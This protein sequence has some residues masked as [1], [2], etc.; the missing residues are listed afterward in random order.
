MSI[1]VL[2][3]LI[4]TGTTETVIN[5][6]NT[7]GL[8]ITGGN[9]TAP[10]F[11]GNLT[12]TSTS[13]LNSTCLNGVSSACYMRTDVAAT[14][15]AG[16]LRIND[17][18]RTEFGTDNDMNIWHDGT[19]NFIKG[20][21]GH[22]IMVNGSGGDVRIQAVDGENSIVAYPN[23]CTTL[24]YDNLERLKTTAT[25]VETYG[26][27][28]QGQY[29]IGNSDGA[30]P[31]WA[32]IFTITASQAYTTA[33]L[34]FNVITRYT[35]TAVRLV[36]DQGDRVNSWWG[37]YRLYSNTNYN[38]ISS[39]N[40]LV[41]RIDN[42][43]LEVWG[44]A[45]FYSNITI[46]DYTDASS[47]NFTVTTH[48]G[49]YGTP[50]TPG[51]FSLRYDF[52]NGVLLN[53][54]LGLKATTGTYGTVETVGTTTGWGGFLTNGI[55]F[56]GAGGSGGMYDDDNNRWMMCGAMGA[57]VEL[58]HNGNSKLCT[59]SAGVCVTGEIKAEGAPN[60][61]GQIE[62]V[63]ASGVRGYTYSDGGGVGITDGDP[64]ND[65]IYLYPQ[66]N[67]IV[68]YTSTV[69]RGYF[70]NNG[71]CVSN[72][73]QGSCLMVSSGLGLK[74]STETYGTVEAIGGNN[75][76]AGYVT[77]G[78]TLMSNGTY[79]GL[80]NDTNDAWMLVACKG[81]TTVLY[82]NGNERICTTG[83]GVCVPGRMCTPYIG[84]DVSG[85]GCIVGGNDTAGIGLANN[86]H[87]ATWYGFSVGPSITGQPIPEGCAAFSVN[88]RTGDAYVAS[89]MYVCGTV[90]TPVVC[91]TTSFNSTGAGLRFCGGTGCGCAV[92]W[93]ASSDC[94]QKKCIE[95]YTNGLEKINR[96]NPVYYNWIDEENPDRD[97]GFIAQEVLEVEPTLVSGSE[98][99]GYGLKYDKFSAL[100]IK[101]I[102]EL[103]SC[104]NELK[105]EIN[106]IKNK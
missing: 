78:V 55:N 27:L 90:Q 45:P 4:T 18:V 104:I 95:P 56:M 62:W 6:I 79:A 17:N 84:L 97:M 74:A 87:L 52:E 34:T 44:L 2:S 59:T 38:A 81:G 69:Q 54:T 61:S 72:C 15:T 47:G 42:D 66:L 21:T 71:L 105:E 101:A 8:T 39:S 37:T 36:A 57:G 32:K 89:W 31:R 33:H 13:S 50:T 64:Y 16:S 14:K 24:S 28:K 82:H 92:D 7:T 106:I 20:Y 11:I 23:S 100:T 35:N 25:G 65:L 67:R 60:G 40:L 22:L 70:D 5:D 102:Q 63:G 91:A 48:Q 85:V 80:F 88:A 29:L 53:P 83:N 41:T 76:W 93:I 19:N 68:F 103:T 58:Y 10:S 73:I 3:T 26:V 51:D 1:R 46:S 9:V 94:R 98:E 49:V 12:G 30:N 86:V 43:T 75:G 96:L 77:N 99:T